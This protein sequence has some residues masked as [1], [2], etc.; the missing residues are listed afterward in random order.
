MHTS[1]FNLFAQKPEAV[2]YSL[3]FPTNQEFKPSSRKRVSLITDLHEIRS[4]MLRYEQQLLSDT[5]NIE[6]TSFYEL[7]KCAKYDY[8]HNS[9][10]L[11]PGM[12]NSAEMA[13]E[14]KR[15]IT[16]LDKMAHK[17]FPD[18]CA[19]LKGCIRVSTK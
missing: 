2:Y 7:F 5:Y 3:Q 17:N 8:F 14:D 18:K 1:S 9:V 6:E 11:H 4:L 19:F 13:A 10:E 16:T 15:L 12:R